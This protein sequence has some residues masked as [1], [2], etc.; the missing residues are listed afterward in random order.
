VKLYSY[1][2]A[3]LVT[4]SEALISEVVVNIGVP[5]SLL[6]SDYEVDDPASGLH[7]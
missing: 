5:R 2:S 1:S 3:R 4:E 6:S 7:P